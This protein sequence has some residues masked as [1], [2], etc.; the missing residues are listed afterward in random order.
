MNYNKTNKGFGQTSTPSEL[1]AEAG[2]AKPSSR[3]SPE[4]RKI[5]R[6]KKPIAIRKS[7]PMN[8][9]CCQKGKSDSEGLLDSL[10]TIRL[11]PEEDEDGAEDDDGCFLR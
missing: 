9:F 1:T 8:Q 6:A 10:S 4:K 7:N 3:S 11:G 5:A 2:E